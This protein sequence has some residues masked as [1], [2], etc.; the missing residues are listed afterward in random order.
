MA[1]EV[2]I[3][4]GF[5]ISKKF[6][7][8]LVGILNRSEATD[9]YAAVNQNYKGYTN[10]LLDLHLKVKAIRARRR[11]QENKH[12]KRRNLNLADTFEQRKTQMYRHRRSTHLDNPYTFNDH[13]ILIYD[14][15]GEI[16]RNSIPMPMVDIKSPTSTISLDQRVIGY[17]LSP[18]ELKLA[19]GTRYIAYRN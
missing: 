15:L 18:R 19:L 10:S 6:A 11:E 1:Q 3:I 4:P 2:E 7:E 8:E 16:I 5:T 14:P 13:G 12:S 9:Q 17:E